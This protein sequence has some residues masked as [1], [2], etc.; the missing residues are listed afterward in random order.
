MFEKTPLISV[1]VPLYNK[2]AWVERCLHS[3]L[4]QTYQNIEILIIND[5]STDKSR[6]LISS[7]DDRRIKIFDKLNGGLA[8]ARNYGIDKAKGKY[9]A[10]ID[11]DDEWEERHLEYIL[12]GFEHYENTV[13]VCS[14]LMETTDGIK[15]N[16][17]KRNLPFNYV[18]CKDTVNYYF[19]DNYIET[20]K[21]GYFLLSGS[22]VLIDTAIIKKN[23]L[24][25]LSNAEPSEDIN[26]WLRL[27]QLGKF[28]FCNYIGLYYHRVDA[29]SIMNKKSKESKLIP[30]FFY[31]ID[32]YQYNGE[33]KR[34]IKKFLVYEYY[35]KAYQNRGLPFRNEELSTKV[36]AGVRI[37]SWNI[38]PYLII[39]YCPQLVLDYIKNYK[40]TI[41][42]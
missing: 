23:N 32:F 42:I 11:A 4:H 14:D 5:G 17:I 2:E 38:F 40:N 19:I 3:I 37:G 27:N 6:D 21:E 30:P 36:G 10:L 20:L 35:K 31:T 1:I 33:D 7:L 15:G 22:S 16:G 29:E 39:R 12:K 8:T 25:F 9:I 13:L 24:K 28:V 18:N 34:N 26:Y 41:S